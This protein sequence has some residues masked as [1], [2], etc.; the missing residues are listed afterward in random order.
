MDGW[1]I[2]FLLGPGLFS[3]AA[4][5]GFREGNIWVYLMIT[6]QILEM[7]DV[8]GAIYLQSYIFITLRI[9]KDPPMEGFEPV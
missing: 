5:I 4:H 7:L 8:I 3:G 9:P 2:N 6:T 1:K